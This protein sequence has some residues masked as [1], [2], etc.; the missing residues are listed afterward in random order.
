MQVLTVVSCLTSESEEAL[1]SS[2]CWAPGR[3]G[4]MCGPHEVSD[5]E[6]A[7]SGTWC[8]QA[9]VTGHPRLK[10]LKQ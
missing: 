2:G 3:G 6:A 8:I 9:A 7:P 10:G 1:L 4:G 5:T